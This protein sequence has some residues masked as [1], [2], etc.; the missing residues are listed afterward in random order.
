[1]SNQDLTVKIG[2]IWEEYVAYTDSYRKIL[3]VKIEKNFTIFKHL[4]D[5]SANPRRIR[6][7]TSRLTLPN[8]K[9]FRLYKDI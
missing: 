7:R 5:T 1:M 9:A 8:T 4:L 3:V 2:Q 6:V